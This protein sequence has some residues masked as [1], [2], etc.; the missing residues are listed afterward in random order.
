MRRM[1]L[2]LILLVFF[3][4][5]L[6]LATDVGGIINTNTTWNLAGSPYL[7]T[8]EVQI[9]EGVTLTI[10]PGV[11]VNTGVGG[12]ISIWG[13]LRAEGTEKSR[14]AFNGVYLHCRDPDTTTLFVQYAN[15]N[16]GQI[17]IEALTA[18]MK[19]S[20][21]VDTGWLWI[22]RA[23]TYIEKNIFVRSG[24]IRCFPYGTGIISI[25]NNVIYDQVGSFG[26]GAIFIAQGP[27][28]DIDSIVFKYNS[29]LSTNKI[30]IDF[31]ITG[32]VVE[33]KTFDATNNYWNTTDSSVI[34]TMIIDRNDDLGTYAY[35]NYMPYLTEPHPDTPTLYGTDFSAD[36][37]TGEVPLR[38]NFTD[39]TKDGV[40]SWLWDFGDGS[41][42][43]EKNPRHTYTNPGSY[44]VSLTITGSLGPEK[45]TKVDFI[46]ALERSKKAMPGIPLLL[47]DD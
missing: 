27:N 6:A 26:E 7:L 16:G 13:T 34:D 28:L 44:S 19:Y 20:K 9:A 47:L 12:T 3:A 2:L 35:V 21:F 5:A 41:T 29:F 31:G 10:E 18:T 36:V 37:N 39:L 4:P 25:R 42:S 45:E 23:N 24:S 33:V 43:T 17:Y 1:I 32:H 22:N 14:I 8:S 46:M 40:T 30:A 15:Y 11:V 38:V